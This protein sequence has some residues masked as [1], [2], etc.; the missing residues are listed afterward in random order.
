F[1]AVET[2]F[3]PEYLE[4]V[5]KEIYNGIDKILK[6]KFDREIFFS[7]QR[8]II[9]TELMRYDN[10]N[11]VLSWIVDQEDEF[12][13]HKENLSV[14]EFIELIKGYKIAD[15]LGASKDTYDWKKANITVVSKED[16]TE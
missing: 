9:D 4:T 11:N 16:P 6:G 2:S 10:P 1:F 3:N 13:A 5:L 15:L 12:A 7:R 8:R 14:S